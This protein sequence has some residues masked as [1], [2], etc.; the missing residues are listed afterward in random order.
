MAKPKKD[1]NEGKVLLRN[2]KARHDYI[3]EDTLEAG[4]ALVGSEV[5]SLREARVVAS[6]AYV[7]I[8]NGEAWLSQLSISEYP[9]ANRFNHAP[10]RDRKLLLH[11]KEIDKLDVASA[12]QGYTILPLEIYLKN[13]RIKVLIGLCKGKQDHDKRQN[14]KEKDAQREMAAAIR[15]RR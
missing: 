5:K 15:N 13:G 7:F 9:W 14:A 11:R 12:R 10:K 2:K 4:V 3:V 8:K 1:E 6:D